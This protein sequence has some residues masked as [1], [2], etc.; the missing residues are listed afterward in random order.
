MYGGKS[1]SAGPRGHWFAVSR[2]L[3]L[4]HL[5]GEPILIPINF[6]STTIW[7]PATIL[8]KTTPGM[9]PSIF[10]GATVCLLILEYAKNFIIFF[11]F[12]SRYYSRASTDQVAEEKLR[13]E[14]LGKYL[15]EKPYQE[16]HIFYWQVKDIKDMC[17]QSVKHDRNLK[18]RKRVSGSLGK[19]NTKC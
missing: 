8:L 14:F 4:H 1:H 2:P 6:L 9:T 15:S 16:L 18:R 11:A 19:E 13:Y 5:L 10:S 17:V 3:Y 7:M 12:F